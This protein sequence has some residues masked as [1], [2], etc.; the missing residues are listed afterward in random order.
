M[1]FY[2]FM[3]V[4]RLD[5]KRKFFTQGAVRHQ[6]RLPKEAVVSHPW[7]CSRPG[8]MG[9]E[10]PEL[11]GGTPAHGSGVGTGWTLRC[12]PAQII[13]QFYDSSPP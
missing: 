10:Q 1:P 11:V 3:I 8:W 6:H 9:P 13:L 4:F 5:V 7:R 2:D 12:L